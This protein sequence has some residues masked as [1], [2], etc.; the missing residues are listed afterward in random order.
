MKIVNRIITAV[1]AV[2][3]FPVLAT[4]YLFEIVLSIDKNSVAYSL[5]SL[6]A[7]TDNMLTG[8]RLGFKESIVSIA[9][10]II[11]GSDRDSG[12][13]LMEIW[14]Q[15]PEDFDMTKK[16]VVASLVFVAVGAVIAVVIL[17]CAI[18]T[19]AYK[20]IIGLGLGGALSFLVGIILFGKAGAPLKD[21]SIDIVTHLADFLM[22]EDPNAIGAL[23]GSLLKGTIDVDVFAMG[24]AVF[25]AM[26]VML[27]IAVWEFA[28]YITLPEKERKIKKIKK[29]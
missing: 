23:A 17:G 9:Q 21:G 28:Y 20:T 4:Q 2:V 19:K 3:T 8:N 1:L 12:F 16:L 25:G 26:I 18:F 15:L 24:G 11:D 10:S 6:F 7:G 29:A 5:I 27:G 22:G 14:S 13:D